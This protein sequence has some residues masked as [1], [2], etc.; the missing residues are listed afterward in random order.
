LRIE[1]IG[2][3]KA[4]TFAAV[5]AAAFGMPPDLSAALTAAA[6][7]PGW[8]HYLAYAEDTPVATAA[9]YVR[10]VVGWLGAAGT[11]PAYR[12]RGAQGALMTRRINDA[13]ALGCRWLVTETG[14]DNPSQPNPSYHNMLRTGFRLA[15]QRANYVATGDAAA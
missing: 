6:G 4:A 10:G 8:Q 2:P 1:A 3:G 11:L 7:Q 5:A 9:L 15:Y 12:R 13:V 14:E